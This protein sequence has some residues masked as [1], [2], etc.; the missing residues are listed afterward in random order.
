[1]AAGS[2]R[3][4][5]SRRASRASDI[6]APRRIPVAARTRSA[7]ARKVTSSPYGAHA[8]ANHVA[9]GSV[10]RSSRSSRVFPTPGGAIT[11]TDEP[12]RSETVRSKSSCRSVS[13]RPRPTRG[14]GSGPPAGSS[15]SPS[16]RQT[17]TGAALPLAWNAGSCST[18][19][20]SR[21]ARHVS[22]PITR[23]PGGAT[24]C[25]RL[26]V[27]TTSPA[28]ASPTCGP[29]PAVTTA[30]PVFTATR[31]DP[32]GTVARR[33]KAARTAR[34]GSSSCATGAPNT[35]IAASPMNLSSVPPNR[36]I[37]A[38]AAVWK[39]ISVRRT[40]SGSASSDR[41][42]NPTRSA[43]RTVTTR[44]S[45]VGAGSSDAPQAM[46]NLAAPGL[47]V[48]HVEQTGTRRV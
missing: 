29:C 28:T 45:S 15:R 3:P 20:R 32:C 10:R 47:S 43:N 7:S 39:G 33:S 38:F 19:N 24:D 35:P 5:S 2:E 44:R 18:S 11:V 36:S 14:V 42:V 46:Q 40:S 31:T 27:L 12:V 4:T 21:T 37:A 34:S 41:S 17:S 23:S 22:S 6:S 9:T 26:A 1:M 30:S 8:P 16:T 25:I 13:S 48:P